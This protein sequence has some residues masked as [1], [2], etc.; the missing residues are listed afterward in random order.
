MKKESKLEEILKD[1][2]S[3]YMQY[4]SIILYNPLQATFAKKT[5]PQGARAKFGFNKFT[6]EVCYCPGHQGN[7]GKLPQCLVKSQNSGFLKKINFS[8]FWGQKM[9]LFLVLMG[10]NNFLGGP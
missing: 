2:N 6:Q 8:N 5:S 9:R 10:P 4:I 1:T 7:C 3:S